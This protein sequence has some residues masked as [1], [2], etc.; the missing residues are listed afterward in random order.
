MHTLLF[1]CDKNGRVQYHQL[2]ATKIAE[3]DYSKLCFL[4]K[5]ARLLWPF[6]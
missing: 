2:S 1:V 4:S 5:L 6:S 3:T